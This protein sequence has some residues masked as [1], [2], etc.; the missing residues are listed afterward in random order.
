[1]KGLAGEGLELDEVSDEG[2]LGGMRGG[3]GRIHM[4]SRRRLCY[5]L[6]PARYHY[7]MLTRSRSSSMRRMMSS[8]EKACEWPRFLVDESLRSTHQSENTG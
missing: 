5:A 2:I 7:G 6:G 8:R 3:I 4:R 1:M